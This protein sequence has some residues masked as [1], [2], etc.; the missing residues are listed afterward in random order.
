MP[1]TCFLA[2]IG[3]MA[4][5]HLLLPIRQLF[6][7][8]WR[9]IGLAPLAAGV[10]LNL[11]ADRSFKKLGTTV[12]PFE[13]SQALAVDGV[14]RIS[15]HPMYLGMVLMLLGIAIL[16]G[17]VAPWF[18]VPL[19]AVGF[20]RAFIRPEERVLDATFADE[21]RAYRRRVRRWI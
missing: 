18:V 12:K 10:A 8:P 1:P 17:S 15:R 4:V 3:S 2:A 6:D 20:D 21:Y 19:L 9:A 13:K 7:W 14:F 5:L 11:L 16:L